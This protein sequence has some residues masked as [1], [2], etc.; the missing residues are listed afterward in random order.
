[1]VTGASA[2]GW[3]IST[4]LV[5][6]VSTAPLMGQADGAPPVTAGCAQS[7][8]VSS[9]PTLV[10]EG[11]CWWVR[12]PD[13]QNPVACATCHDDPVLTRQWTASFPK[14]KPLPPPS[15]RV[16]TLLQANAE[17]VSRHY[18]VADPRPAATAITAYLAWLGAGVPVAPGVSAGQPVFA[19]RIRQLRLS[20]ARGQ[21][22]FGDRCRQCHT[23]SRLASV[24]DRFPRPANGRAESLETFVE[25]HHP[26]DG[27]LPW[28]SPGM[29][30]LI[31][32]IVEYAA[33][34]PLGFARSTGSGRAEDHVT[35]GAGGTR[36]GPTS[37]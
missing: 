27:R 24:L 12:S 2:I 31:A 35:P 23:P 20:A 30:D 17:A 8:G 1:M 7:P 22:L 18:R 19:E 21:A 26:G 37:P 25:R 13:P 10:T 11:E 32:Y 15:A 36:R 3:A 29:A 16:M 34:R 4:V 28:D 5:V 33:G 6:G 9:R 14:F